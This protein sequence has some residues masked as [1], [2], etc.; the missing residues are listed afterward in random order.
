M[1]KINNI[2]TSPNGEKIRGN[3]LLNKYVLD[4]AITLIIIQ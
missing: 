1:K 2:I 4:K 3:N